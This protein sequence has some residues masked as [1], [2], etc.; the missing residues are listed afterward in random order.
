[1][2]LKSEV[3]GSQK[4]T[5]SVCCETPV[6]GRQKSEPVSVLRWNSPGALK[7][8][9]SG[10]TFL[11][12]QRT[13]DSLRR[14]GASSHGSEI[15]LPV[16]GRGPP[17]PP[18]NSCY[19]PGVSASPVLFRWIL[20]SHKEAEAQLQKLLC[21]SEDAPRNTGSSVQRDC[22][23][24]GGGSIQVGEFLLISPWPRSRT[25]D[26]QRRGCP[27]TDRM[28]ASWGG[29]TGPAVTSVHRAEQF[30][31]EAIPSWAPCVHTGGWKFSK[32]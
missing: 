21:C 2:P 16:P 6:H 3:R 7:Q 12:T 27:A 10:P 31:Y 30:I 28:V 14:A 17:A 29:S 19:P 22:R 24:P 25:L 8:K 1:M 26:T 9:Q 5:V 32:T 23:H 11:Y 18:S 4:H 15:F 13:R 20:C